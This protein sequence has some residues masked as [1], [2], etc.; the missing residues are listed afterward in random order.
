[1]DRIERIESPQP[2]ERAWHVTPIRKRDPEKEREE[3]RKREQ[4]QQ[5]DVP[6][7]GGTDSDEPPHLI[8]VVA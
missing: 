4:A 2:H 1:M 5:R 6:R 3:Q 7:A 8:D